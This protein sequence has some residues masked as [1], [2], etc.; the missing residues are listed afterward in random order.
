MILAFYIL[1]AESYPSQMSGQSFWSYCIVTYAVSRILRDGWFSATLVPF[2]LTLLSFCLAYPLVPLRQTDAYRTLLLSFG[3]HIIQ[4][5][6]PYSPSFSSLAPRSSSFAISSILHN[7]FGRVFIPAIRLFIPYFLLLLV[8]LVVAIRDEIFFHALTAS[9][10]GMYFLIFLIVSLS[11]LIISLALSSSSV[12][13]A[14]LRH[15]DVPASWDLYGTNVGLLTRYHFFST[16]FRYS[17]PYY[18]PAPLNLLQLVLVRLPCFVL[19]LSRQKRGVSWIRGT[20]EPI[21]WRI[22]VLPVALVVGVAWR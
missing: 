18:Y 1:D 7:L 14:P 19:L 11:S 17:A 8:L 20:M 6:L 12:T 16:V 3:L 9:D 13:P 15:P 5:L 2:T 10:F 4:S 21:L 22:T